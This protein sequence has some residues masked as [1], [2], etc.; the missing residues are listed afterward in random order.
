MAR[1]AKPMRHLEDEESVAPTEVVEIHFQRTG[2]VP[3]VRPSPSRIGRRALNSN[4]E[5]RADVRPPPLPSAPPRSSRKNTAARRARSAMRTAPTPPEASDLA[6]ALEPE[7]FEPLAQ[8]P[9]FARHHARPR[10]KLLSARAWRRLTGALVATVACA[11]G[12]VFV[13]AFVGSPLSP[14]DAREALGQ[15]MPPED[16]EVFIPEDLAPEPAEVKAPRQ[17]PQL[18]AS[19]PRRREP[20]I[21]AKGALVW[22]V[23]ST[24]V[25]S[26]F[27]SRADPLLRTSAE[28]RGI[29][30][31]CPTGTPV[32]AIADGVVISATRSTRSG[33]S[34]RVLHKAKKMVTLYA[35][36]SRADVAE[37]DQLRA[38][39]PIGLSGSTGRV[40]GPHL[41]FEV[42][43]DRKA[44]D[45][46]SFTYRRAPASAYA[47]EPVEVATA[48]KAEAETASESPDPSTRTPPSPTATAGSSTGEPTM[49]RSV[50]H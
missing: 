24:S 6:T 11:T 27:G 50:T 12:M 1:R 35:H 39:Q 14:E 19:R 13:F 3:V 5:V 20:R 25:S 32:L 22:P 34:I 7:V 21:S 37:G 10:R 31:R 23:S 46:L 9:L 44:Q 42:W 8:P 2:R 47:A 18:Q 26:G 33:V 15:A 43:Q 41:H 40:T 29:D 48:S 28:H 38:G 49:T 16:E 4:V 30:V 45:P 17:G 36:M